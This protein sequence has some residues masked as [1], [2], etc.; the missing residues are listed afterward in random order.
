M[1]SSLLDV[2]GA[3]EVSDAADVADADETGAT[4]EAGRPG[5]VALASNGGAAMDATSGSVKLVNDDRATGRSSDG[6]MAGEMG[7]ESV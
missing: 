2:V 3:D 6:T 7:N 5:G 4:F 1:A